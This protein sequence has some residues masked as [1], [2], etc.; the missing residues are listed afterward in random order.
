MSLNFLSQ[1]HSLRYRKSFNKPLS[2][3]N[4]YTTV[5]STQNVQ[6]WW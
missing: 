5:F 6:K 3:S 1:N 4:N 2:I